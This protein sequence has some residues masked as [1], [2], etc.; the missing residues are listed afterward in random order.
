VPDPKA[1]RNR[2]GTAS[3]ADEPASV[4]GYP[5]STPVVVIGAGPAGLT[6]AY[7]L[8]KRGQPCV[9]LEADDQVG[10]ISR[11]VERDGFRFDIGGHRFFSKS[12]QVRNLWAEMMQPEQFLRRPRLS[13]ILYRGKLFAY[14]LKP[15]NALRQ[16]GP[17][18]AVCCVASY[19][20]AR[21]RPPA[22]RSTFEGWTTAAF[23]RRLYRIFFKTY[24]E[25][26]WGVP[27]ETIQ[28]DWAAQRIKS[29]NLTRVVWDA[30]RPRRWS[31]RSQPTSLIDEFDYPALGPGQLWER[32][33][34]TVTDLGGSIIMQSPVL[35][36]HRDERGAVA[37]SHIEQSTVTTKRCSAVISSM[38][39]ADLVRAID[40]PPPAY[41]LESADRLKHRA[42]MT[43]AL[44]VPE[45]CG[46]PDNWIYVHDPNV[47]VGR[48][49]NFRSWSPAMVPEGFSCLGLEYFVQEGDEMWTSSDADL[50]A[51]G[52]DE[53][54]RLG[55]CRRTD[56]QRGYVV[57][58]PKAYPIYD[59]D[60]AHCVQMIR[61]WMICELPNV[62]PVGRNGMHRYNNQDH[63]MLTAARVVENLFGA[64]HDVWSINLDDDYHEEID[65]NRG[66][67]SD[68][69]P[70]T[71]STNAPDPS[72]SLMLAV[73]EVHS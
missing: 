21:V 8:V 11:T 61:D 7:E 26:V 60:Y 68:G 24:T 65:P 55:L 6:A 4:D 14:P 57:R 39:I 28:A 36:V 50:I 72:E 23:G 63:S 49:Q 62:Y 3:R 20:W 58:M 35:T 43:V 10:G 47:R 33:A 44:V 52:T 29:L 59:A 53:I 73:S 67:D 40:P 16:L 64:N 9:V 31:R 70:S 37:V 56:V 45:W 48:I 22:D 5:T 19:A 71:G 30:L 12:D 17:I 25:K 18:E 15:I 34:R 69:R 46:F 1:D 54:A 2:A 38:P 13:R 27:A 42:F 66:R 51:L 32:C 41:V